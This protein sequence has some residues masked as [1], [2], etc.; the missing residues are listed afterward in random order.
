[1]TRT[2]VVSSNC[3]TGGIASALDAMLP[4]DSI[5]PCPWTGAN[6]SAT[7]LRD[8]LRSADVWVTAADESTRS[9]LLPKDRALGVIRVPQILFDAFHPDAIRI[10]GADG[11]LLASPVARLHSA[12]V[13]WGWRNRLDAPDIALRF[14]PAVMERLGYTSAWDPA[15]DRLRKIVDATDIDFDR[16]F[17]PLRRGMPFMLTINHVR[18][19]GL[20]SL[21]RQVATM[22]GAPSERVDFPWETT[23]AD[24]PL[25]N[26]PYWPVYPAIAESLGTRGGFFWRAPGGAY[27][28]LDEFVAASLAV[29][30]AY[31]RSAVVVPALDDPR[32]DEVLADALVAS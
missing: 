27:M 30:A 31:D 14:R 2:I 18:L 12:I 25:A 20:V 17:L 4:Q 24:R 22:L 16:F 28:S 29:Y 13:V 5:R 7:A 11:A 8:E 32:F 1:M 23:L 19:A 21:A 15:V 10:A 3:Q 26:G 6:A 9:A